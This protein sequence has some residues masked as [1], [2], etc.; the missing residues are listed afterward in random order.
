MSWLDLALIEVAS[1]S[2]SHRGRECDGESRLGSG[3]GRL[4]WTGLPCHVL[5]LPARAW[6]RVAQPYVRNETVEKRPESR[7]TNTDICA[8]RYGSDWVSGTPHSSSCRVK[9]GKL[10]SRRMAL[11]AEAETG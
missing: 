2:K 7:V 8:G 9:D 6:M 5:V 10:T 3:S 4:P 1:T 11:R